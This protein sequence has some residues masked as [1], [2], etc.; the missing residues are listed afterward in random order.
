MATIVFTK[1][2]TELA[3]LGIDTSQQAG[4]NVKKA[5][6]GG[7]STSTKPGLLAAERDTG[8][9]FA[10]VLDTFKNDAKYIIIFS[11]TKYNQLVRENI[12]NYGDNRIY[13]ITN[14]IS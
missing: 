14:R 9:N 13:K 3:K 4:S 6:T 1:L 11:L 10:T 8:G 2:Q 5:F 7:K 12:I